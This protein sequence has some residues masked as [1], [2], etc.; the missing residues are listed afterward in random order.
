MIEVTT[1][2]DETTTH[3]LP[4]FK[5][6]ALGHEWESYDGYEYDKSCSRCNK[7]YELPAAPLVP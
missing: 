7:H 6:Q 5:C 4:W 1:E 2:P 3:L